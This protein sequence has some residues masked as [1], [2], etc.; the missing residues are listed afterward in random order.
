MQLAAR[1]TASAGNSQVGEINV[2]NRLLCPERRRT[3]FTPSSMIKDKTVIV[4]IKHFIVPTLKNNIV[5]F[6]KVSAT[7]QMGAV[8]FPIIIIYRQHTR[9]CSLFVYLIFV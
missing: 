4:S 5:N 6:G 2:Q 3:Q 1:A 7:S 9:P 8:P